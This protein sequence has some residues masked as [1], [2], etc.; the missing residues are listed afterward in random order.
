MHSSLSYMLSY[1]RDEAAVGFYLV[2][3]DLSHTTVGKFSSFLVYWKTENIS[4]YFCF[5]AYFSELL[6]V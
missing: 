3:L 5:T 4:L 1:P 6:F 2:L